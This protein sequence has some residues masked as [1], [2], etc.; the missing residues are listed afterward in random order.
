MGKTLVETIAEAMLDKKG[1][2]VVSLDLRKI[3][4]AISDHFVVCNADST[5]NVSSISDHIEEH[6]YETLG[7]K[8]LRSQGRENGFWVILDYGEVVVHVFLTQYRSFYRLEDLWA[9]ADRKE[10]RDE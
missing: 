3:G 6:V 2:D 5:T 10:Y 8:V 9:D 7:L 4:T 1:R